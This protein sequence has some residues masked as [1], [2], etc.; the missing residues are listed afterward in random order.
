MPYRFVF[1]IKSCIVSNFVN[2]YPETTFI[3]G[4]TD[5]VG[6]FGHSS[7][8]KHLFAFISCGRLSQIETGFEI[9]IKQSIFPRKN[10][11]FRKSSKKWMSLRKA[12][13]SSRKISGDCRE[14]SPLSIIVLLHPLYDIA[15]C[16]C[17]VYLFACLLQFKNPVSQ[18]TGKYAK[19]MQ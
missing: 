14:Q 15:V 1:L 3:I 18:L 8:I 2:G 9:I 11:N 17:C 10:Q 12:G 6:Y 5:V 16:Y 7:F 19:K 4:C 13:P